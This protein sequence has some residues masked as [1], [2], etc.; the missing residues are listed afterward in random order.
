[1][2]HPIL[3]PLVIKKK[4]REREEKK[5]P[6]RSVI[7]LGVVVIFFFPL[8]I[9]YTLIFL[10][11]TTAALPCCLIKKPCYTIHPVIKLLA[12]IL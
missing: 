3:L 4:K 6:G 2:F 12:F 9:S 7:Y 10:S 8:P 1:M 11:L 5:I